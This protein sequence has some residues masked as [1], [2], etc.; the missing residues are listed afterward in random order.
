MSQAREVFAEYWAARAAGAGI[1]NYWDDE[2]LIQALDRVHDVFDG[3]AAA[4]R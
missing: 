4:A 1:S 3:Q 2:R